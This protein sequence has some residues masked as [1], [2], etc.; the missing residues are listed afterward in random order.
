MNSIPLTE[1]MRCCHGAVYRTPAAS[2]N[3]IKRTL[4]VYLTLDLKSTCRIHSRP[5]HGG[6]FRFAALQFA[7]DR[8]TGGRAEA[9]VSAPENAAWPVSTTTGHQSRGCALESV[10]RR[11]RLGQNE[12]PAITYVTGVFECHPCRATRDASRPST[13][14]VVYNRIQSESCCAPTN[15]RIGGLS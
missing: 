10:P 14:I 7:R 4:V 13:S 3:N 6:S 2:S 15:T 5:P 8:R 12:T 1:P 11:D 9:S